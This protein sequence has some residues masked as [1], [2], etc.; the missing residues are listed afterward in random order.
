MPMHGLLKVNPVSHSDKNKFIVYFR[1]WDQAILSELIPKG[2]LEG[3]R[4]RVKV[5]NSDKKFSEILLPS[6]RQVRVPNEDVI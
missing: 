1:N 4:I 2:L 5:L 3:S 6:G